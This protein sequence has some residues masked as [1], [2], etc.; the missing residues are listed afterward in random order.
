M[1]KFEGK[2]ILYATTHGPLF[3]PGFGGTVG[4]NFTSQ[5]SAQKKATDMTIEGDSVTLLL[6]S[7]KGIEYP[8]L[9]HRSGFTHLVL[10]K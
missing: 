5:S 4:P 2:K 10:A 7:D 6:V 8:V 3:I 1:S 9:I